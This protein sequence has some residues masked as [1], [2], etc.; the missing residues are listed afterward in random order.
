MSGPWKRC[1]LFLFD[2]GEQG[3]VFVFAGVV[4][5]VPAASAAAAA[6]QLWRGRGCLPLA[7]HHHV[8]NQAS[9]MPP[10]QTICI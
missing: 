9:V 6:T 8:L 7:W 5:L 2:R 1:G 10:A 3:S 4:G